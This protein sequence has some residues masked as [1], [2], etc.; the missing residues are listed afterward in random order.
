M[1]LLNFL[2]PQAETAERYALNRLH[3]S[4]ARDFE[5]HLSSCAHCSN[6]VDFA[7]EFVAL[8]SGTDPT[9]SSETIF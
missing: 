9:V 3:P 2:C 5:G 8:L 4:A 7:D 1:A 6:T